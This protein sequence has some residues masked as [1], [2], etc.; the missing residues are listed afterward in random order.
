MWDLE[1]E[2]EEAALVGTAARPSDGRLP[3]AAVP[4]E[5]RRLDPL[6]RISPDRLQF[7]A[8]PTVAPRVLLE[9]RRALPNRHAE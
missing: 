2:E 6:R 5:R 8:Q 3:V 7:A 1:V 9:R 4:V